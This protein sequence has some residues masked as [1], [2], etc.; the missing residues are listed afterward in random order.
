VHNVEEI[1]NQRS[2]MSIQS[3]PLCQMIVIMSLV[4]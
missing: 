2:D 4:W 3:C 1:A